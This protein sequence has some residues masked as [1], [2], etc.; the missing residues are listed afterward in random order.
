MQA[1]QLQLA[2]CPGHTWTATARRRLPPA[3]PASP[4]PPQTTINKRSG[5]RMK[6]TA[7]RTPGCV[8]G[9]RREVAFRRWSRP[10]RRR[11]LSAAISTDL[12]STLY[13][14]KVWRRR[15]STDA[16][17]QRHVNARDS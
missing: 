7:A 9:A 14:P 2:I 4:P 6:S 15:R 5:V 3:R 10:Q 8:D 11:S 16:P 1:L 17:S 13:R 12:A